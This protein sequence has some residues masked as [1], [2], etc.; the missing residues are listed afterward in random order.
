[1]RCTLVVDRAQCRAGVEETVAAALRE[2]V[3]AVQLREKTATSRELH[4][5]ALLLRRLTRRYDALLVI[6]DRA[7]VALAVEADGVHL[8]WQSMPVEAAR[9]VMGERALIGRSA[10]N[11]AEAR[12]AAADGADYLF[13]GPVF[14]TPSKAGLVPVLGLDALRA[15]RRDVAIPVIGLGGIDASNAAKVLATG[16]DGIAVIRAIL[17]ADDPSLATAQLMAAISPT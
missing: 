8:G 11:M 1:M 15:I 4:E 5:A 3:S 14:D 17:A 16:V 7:D 2:G 9:R 13:A 12:Q 10:H 6:N